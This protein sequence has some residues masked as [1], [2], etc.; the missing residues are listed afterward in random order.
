MHSAS[1]EGSNSYPPDFGGSVDSAESF[2]PPSSSPEGLSQTAA[3]AA[4]A[5][6][7]VV[8]VVEMTAESGT[9]DLVHLASFV[10][11]LPCFPYYPDWPCCP[12][13]PCSPYYPRFPWPVRHFDSVAVRLSPG[14]TS[15]CFDILSHNR[16]IS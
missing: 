3:A 11:C 4:V 9:A 1:S 13:L 14:W 15:F 7:V 6:E 16:P 2:L 8:E 5:A 12:C 10:T